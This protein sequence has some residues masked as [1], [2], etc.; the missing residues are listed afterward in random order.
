VVNGPIDPSTGLPFYTYNFD[1]CTGVKLKH[2]ASVDVVKTP[3]GQLK[4]GDYRTF[5]QGGWGGPGNPGQLLA[6]N[7]AKVYPGDSVEVGVVSGLGFSIKLTGSNAVCK[8]LP[9]KQPDV[10]TVDLV[11]GPLTAC[12]GQNSGGD[13]T[14]ASGVF[15]GQVL[16][17]Q[18]NV[19]FSAAG[20][21][22]SGLGALQIANLTTTDTLSGALLTP[23]QVLAL[24]GQ[25]ISL[26][27]AEANTVLGGGTGT[28][29]LT[30]AQLNAWWTS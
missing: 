17:L 21:G 16:A 3:D 7:F 22:P 29:G 25:T 12:T 6:T 9:G 1:C 26:V 24:N 5:T 23:A 14:T 18:L 2:Q 28:Y 19:D 4:V 8:Y 11:A 30:V 15:G 13:I 27:L 10:L 20:I